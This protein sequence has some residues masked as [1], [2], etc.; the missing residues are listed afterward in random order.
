VSGPPAQ[1]LVVDDDPLITSGLKFALEGDYDVAVAATRAEALARLERAPRTAVALVDLGL[2][3]AAH[4]PDEGFELIAAIAG[5]YPAVRTLVL[6]GQNDAGN[7]HHALALGAT[8]FIAKPAELDV[9]V[10]RIAHHVAVQRAERA[11]RA[12]AASGADPGADT[13]VGLPGVSSRIRALDDL[14]GRFADSPYPVLV[15]GESGVGKELV[16]R[17]LHARGGR[18]GA[19]FRAV[20]CAA[21]PPDLLEAQLFGATRGAYT[22]ATA[23]AVGFFEAAGAGTLFLD[24]IGELPL[25]LQAKLLRVL[26]N[27]EFYRLGE[28]APRTSAARVVAATNRDLAAAAALG[29]FR[30]DLF[31]RLNVLVVEVPPLREREGDVPFLIE[32]FIAELGA[33]VDLADDA[34]DLLARYDFPGNVRELKNI[35]IRLAAKYASRT[36]DAA[37]LAAELGIAD[38]RTRAIGA[39]APT[40][41]TATRLTEGDFNLDR[42]LKRVERAYI[43]AALALAGGKL[44]RA[45]RLLGVNRS[46]LY[47]RIERLRKLDP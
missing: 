6:S 1:L 23:D 41:E 31:H 39:E 18:A 17:A 3:P 40:D 22:G 16:A 32:R 35:V 25:T 14:V 29:D 11:V 34:L 37:T 43:D 21:L 38:A 4:G 15:T 47:S 20:N 2:P 36:I 7:V 9:L 33:P 28:T 42:E 24:E 44:A 27:G 45:A 26:E 46:T 13:P 30:E 19:P 5:R 10:A 12:H 8:D